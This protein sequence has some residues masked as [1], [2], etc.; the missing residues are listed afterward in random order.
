[1]ATYYHVT[2]AAYNEGEDLLSWD[3][4]IERY[5]EAPCA[6][7][8][9]ESDCEE[10]FDGYMVSL[11]REDQADEIEYIASMIEGQALVL[12]IE[13]DEQWE[14]ELHF[15]INGEGYTAAMMGRI[16]AEIIVKV[17]PAI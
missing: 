6:W 5:G 15:G 4:Y 14:R 9:D 3:R 16:P 10:G 1:M 17:E 11:L 12:T 7:K 13:T 8:W 2:T